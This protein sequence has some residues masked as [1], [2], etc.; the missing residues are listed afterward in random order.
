MIDAP[1]RTPNPEVTATPH[2]LV[3][4][5]TPAASEATDPFT[6]IAS[7][8]VAAL[9]RDAPANAAPRRVAPAASERQAAFGYD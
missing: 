6:F 2:R 1:A 7:A 5:P 9:C 4:R 8:E 3:L